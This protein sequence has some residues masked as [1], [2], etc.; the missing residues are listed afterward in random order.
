MSRQLGPP[1]RTTAADR[2]RRY[3]VR[4][5]GDVGQPTLSVDMLAGDG[6]GSG[7]PRL[8]SFVA[9][10]PTHSTGQQLATGDCQLLMPQGD[11]VD[12]PV[13]HNEVLSHH[14]DSL[15]DLSNERL[16]RLLTSGDGSIRNAPIH[17]AF[18]PGIPIFI[19]GQGRDDRVQT[20]SRLGV[21]CN[22]NLNETNYVNVP[23]PTTIRRDAYRPI[24]M[25][26]SAPV[27]SYYREPVVDRMRMQSPELSKTDR[28]VVGELINKLGIVDGGD[29]FK[30][31][32][33]LKNILPIISVAPYNTK[34]IIKL[35]IPHVSGQLFKLWMDGVAENVDW[36]TLH[37]T[38]LDTFIP[39]MRRREIEVF[40]L[41]RPQR[42]EETFSEYCEN[43]IAAGFALKSRLSESEV[44]DIAM[45]KCNPRNK[46]Q[47]SFG[48][49]PR[50][51]NDLRILA[52]KVTSSLKAENR[53]FGDFQNMYGNSRVGSEGHVRRTHNVQQIGGGRANV[54][55]ISCFK[56][57]KEGHIARNCT[58]QPNLNTK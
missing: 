13:R 20:S 5:V 38:I 2:Q 48:E 51:I 15:L 54:R 1:Y 7:E 23:E 32:Q 52:R 3:L 8:S 53:Y 42:S 10:G 33:F 37:Q 56:C 41:D 29:E 58:S 25:I 44:I 9:Y 27:G 34:D 30:L 21:G 49:Y 39:P 16:D 11:V 6:G 31:V 45:N 14:Q 47:F 28:T 55:P 12:E 18:I 36:D 50:N 19:Q 17:N 22:S 57:R 46:T 4:N 26:R 40:E 35:S 24:E 43:I